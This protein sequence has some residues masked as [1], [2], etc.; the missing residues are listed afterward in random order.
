MQP[1]HLGAVHGY[2]SQTRVL[3]PPARSECRAL[4][5]PATSAEPDCPSARGKDDQ[6]ST[7]HFSVYCHLFALLSRF[8]PD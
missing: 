4:P 8:L 6:G 5:T 2:G 1:L 3:R 7:F